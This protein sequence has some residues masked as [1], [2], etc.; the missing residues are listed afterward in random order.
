MHD[1]KNMISM[2]ALITT[3]LVTIFVQYSYAQLQGRYYLKI[4][5]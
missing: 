2:K 4:K 5:I 1:L 3:V